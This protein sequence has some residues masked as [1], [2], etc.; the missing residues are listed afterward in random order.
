MAQDRYVHSDDHNDIT[1]PVRPRR[2]EV[3][4]GDDRRRKWPDEAKIAIVAEALSDGAVVSRVARRHDLTPSQL[5]GWIK[6]FRA[7]ALMAVASPAGEPSMFARAVVDMA[8]VQSAQPTPAQIGEASAIEISIGT[9][10]VLIRGA[11]DTKTLA[12][13]LKA[14]KVLA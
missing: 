13:V 11:A 14:L 7:E 3:I 10:T 4:S 6:T 12:L 1:K 8:P 2:I 9:A 5:F